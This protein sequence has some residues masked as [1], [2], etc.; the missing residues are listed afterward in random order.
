MGIL[1]SGSIIGIIGASIGVIASGIVQYQV[2][3]KQ[4]HIDQK[5]TA[6]TKLLEL[7]K[8]LHYSLSKVKVKHMQVSEIY[9]QRGNEFR[10]YVDF[11]DESEEC[12]QDTTEIVMYRRMF[13][14][15][16]AIEDKQTM[17]LF[18]AIDDYFIKIKDRDYTKNN[19]SLNIL[20]EQLDFIM[21]LNNILIYNI[22]D[23]MYENIASKKFLFKKKNEPI[24]KPINFQ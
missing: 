1:E 13:S 23:S 11:D 19:D 12:R 14:P 4:V 2:Y 8:K 3:K 6:G 24:Y 17:Q 15:V 20:S 7:S 22:Q 10:Y 5:I 21:T 18:N 9:R 16:I